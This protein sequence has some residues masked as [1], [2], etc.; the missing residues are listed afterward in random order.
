STPVV[1]ARLAAVAGTPVRDLVADESRGRNRWTLTR[2]QR[3]TWSEELPGGNVMV[4]GELWSDPDPAVAELSIE[5][6]FAESL[7]VGMGDTLDFDVQG[8]P[9]SFKITSI[10]EVDWASFRINFFL[11]VEPGVMEDAPGWRLAAARI[12]PEREGTL[13]ARVVESYPN[14][15]V[16]RIR[17]L[18]EKV[19]GTLRRIA[20]A[21]RLL[22]G[23]TVL[24][25]IAILAGAVAATS[26][27]RGG[28]AALLKS[29]GV[30]RRGVAGLFAIEYGLLGLVAGAFGGLGALVLSYGFLRFALELPGW[31]SLTSVPLAAAG[32]AALAAVA[33]LAASAKPLRA[34][35]IETLRAGG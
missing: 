11:L 26:L 6:G 19:A 9:M 16:L 27:K 7:G 10:R 31:P 13:Q 33:G 8:L 34:S 4:E 1:M 30:T 25:G 12:A 18:L 5:A 35:P 14:V 23:F 21:V 20:L 22:G 2:E 17:P 32:T 3:L 15:G 29:M 28:E 24:V